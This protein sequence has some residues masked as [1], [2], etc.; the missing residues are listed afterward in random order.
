MPWCHRN[1][2]LI[3]HWIWFCACISSLL[4]Q[5][6]DSLSL[7]HHINLFSGVARSSALVSEPVGCLQLLAIVG[8]ALEQCW[9]VIEYHRMTSKIKSRPW[10][11][12]QTRLLVDWHVYVWEGLLLLVRGSLHLFIARAFLFWDILLALLPFHIT[13]RRVAGLALLVIVYI[14]GDFFG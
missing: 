12:R 9:T 5:W 3:V 8:A 10:W 1:C 2:C 11:S 13:F 4:F 7:Q 14:R 6:N